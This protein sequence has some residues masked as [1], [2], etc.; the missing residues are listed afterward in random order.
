MSQLNQDF[1]SKLAELEAEK[2]S[3]TEREASLSEQLSQAEQEIELANRLLE[4]SRAQ[5]EE[6]KKRHAEKVRD[7]LVTCIHVCMVK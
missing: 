1:E 2:T 5:I 3:Y 6:M 7:S 4:E